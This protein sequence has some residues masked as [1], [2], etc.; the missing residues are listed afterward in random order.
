MARVSACESLTLYIPASI[1][2]DRSKTQNLRCDASLDHTWLS[3]ND[4]AR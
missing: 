2:Q 3:Y 1:T 4:C